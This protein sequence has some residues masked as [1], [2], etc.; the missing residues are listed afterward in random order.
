VAT[1]W[2]SHLAGEEWDFDARAFEAAGGVDEDFDKYL[3]Y[4]RFTPSGA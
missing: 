2:G 4:F 1:P 3:S